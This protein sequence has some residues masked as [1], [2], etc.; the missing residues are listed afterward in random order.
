M[1]KLK[2]NLDKTGV[3][4]ELAYQWTLEWCL[5]ES[6]T[7]SALF[8]ES[9]K[10]IH[11]TIFKTNF[12]DFI[13]MLKKVNSTKLNKVKLASNLA[14]KIK[15]STEILKNDLEKDDYL[16]YIILSIKHACND[17]N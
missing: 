8:K 11:P 4:L 7:L 15:K 17:G 14:Y 6:P 1:L 3:K 12:D 2:A 10:E 5:F 16:K 13:P 9:L